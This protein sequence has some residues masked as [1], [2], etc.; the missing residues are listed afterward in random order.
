MSFS[1]TN[2]PLP[3]ANT[4]I[5]YSYTTTYSD[6]TLDLVCTLTVATMNTVIVSTSGTITLIKIA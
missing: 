1:S 5:G 6:S 3:T 2:T 4:Q